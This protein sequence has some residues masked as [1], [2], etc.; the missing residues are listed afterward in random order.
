MHRAASSGIRGSDTTAP[1]L[2]EP[3]LRGG[4]RT[5][6]AATYDILLC[7]QWAFVCVCALAAISTFV[8]M[9]VGGSVCAC[10]CMCVA[11]RVHVCVAVCVAVCVRVC[12]SV[13]SCRA[14]WECV[15]V[16]AFTHIYACV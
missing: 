8:H 11:V 3:E 5:A 2:C 12:A 9:C 15:L 6:S 7:T 13:C 14:W 1:P 10:V 4:G 16:S